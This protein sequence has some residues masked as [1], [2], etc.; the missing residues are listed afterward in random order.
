MS[1]IWAEIVAVDGTAA[2][3]IALIGGLIGLVVHSASS[4]HSKFVE[5]IVTER[6]KW[7]GELRS[8]FADFAY[9]IQE[10]ELAWDTGD[11]AQLTEKLSGAK[12]K[13]QIIQLKLNRRAELDQ[14]IVRIIAHVIWATGGDKTS[15]SRWSSLL[16]IYC[17]DLLKEEWEKAKI[18]SLGFFG[19]LPLRF[20]A[21]RRKAEYQRRRASNPIPAV[22]LELTEQYLAARDSRR[23]ENQD[24][25]S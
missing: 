9:S 6:I 21:R 8:D 15:Y 18:E 4:R 22:D 12:E 20:R 17:N 23:T 19:S 10:V 2:A 11:A 5:T 1:G 7:V 25:G 13:A 24:Q 16:K 14:E 3:I